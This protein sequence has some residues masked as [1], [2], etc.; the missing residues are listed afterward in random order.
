MPTK[1][2]KAMADALTALAPQ[3]PFADAE[4]IRPRLKRGGMRDLPPSIAVWLCTVAH[5]RHAYTDYDELLTD[6][7]GRD[8]ARFFVLDAINAQLEDWQATRFLTGEED[9]SA[10]DQNF[11]DE[12]PE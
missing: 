7:Y 12:A 11:D 1:R 9:L 10:I 4:A 8:A 5:I 6:G 2:Q 3:M